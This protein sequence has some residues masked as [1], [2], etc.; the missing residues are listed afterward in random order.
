MKNPKITPPLRWVGG[1]QRLLPA[2]LP[3]LTGTGRLIEPFV[4]AGSVFL[5]ASQR[6]IVINDLNRDL[7]AM[8]EMLRDAPSDYIDGARTLFTD[9]MHSQHAYLDARCKFNGSTDLRERA[10]LFLYLNKF[11]FNGLFRMNRS[12]EYNVPYGHP[13][14]LPAFPDA[15]LQAMAERLKSATILHGDFRV[16]MAMAATGDVVYCDP[17]YADATPGA[18]SFVGYTST[19]FTINDQIDLVTLAR[20]ACAR[21]ATVVLS[22]HDTNW[23][24]DLYAGMELHSVDVRRSIAANATR[25]TQ[26]GELIAV[27]RPPSPKLNEDDGLPN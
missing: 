11:N 6:D 22:N 7:V 24:R 12:G 20:D 27:L 1:K 17:P 18:R 16:P 15:Q 2:L 23:V 25:R 5:N 14:T 9:S 19:G 4:G 13:K 8:Y 21:G 3:L 10:V 26:A